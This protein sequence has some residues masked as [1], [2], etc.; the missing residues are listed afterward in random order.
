VTSAEADE[1]L[2][3]ALAGLALGAWDL[4]V[5][6]WMR[7]SHPG[8]QAVIASWCRRSWQAGLAVGRDECSEEVAAY[9]RAMQTARTAL[10]QVRGRKP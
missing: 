5:R 7:A 2:D 8:E 6:D 10:D 1:M 3:Q 9:H 4:E